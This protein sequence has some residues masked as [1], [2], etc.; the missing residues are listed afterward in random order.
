MESIERDM[1]DRWIPSEEQDNDAAVYLKEATK[2]FEQGQL[3]TRPENVWSVHLLV[4]K[5]PAFWTLSVKVLYLPGLYYSREQALGAVQ[6]AID[7]H[8]LLRPGVEIAG[9]WTTHRA[10]R[11][12]REVPT[13]R[14]RIW[15][16][17]W[18]IFEA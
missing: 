6:G 11:E 13:I 9:G 12:G 14:G 8:R 2:R 15:K 1:L 7:T 3:D 5:R 18:A 16:T 10:W 17:D 4:S